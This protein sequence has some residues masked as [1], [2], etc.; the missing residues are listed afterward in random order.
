MKFIFS[1]NLFIIIIINKNYKM[2]IYNCAICFENFN[3]TNNT[4]CCT[5]KH[6]HFLCNECYQ[7]WEHSCKQFEKNFTCPICRVIIKPFFKD[8]DSDDEDAITIT[9]ITSNKN[10]NYY[11]DVDNMDVYDS[12]SIENDESTLPLKVGVLTKLASNYGEICYE[13]SYYTICKEL[14]D[15]S[16]NKY[17]VSIISNEVFDMITKDCI[18]ILQENNNIRY[19]KK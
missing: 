18:G 11:V 14:I 4:F 3:K 10:I 5:S 19:Y 16:G 6:K 7:N 2:E 15:N 13:N 12:D 8:Y 17:L 9:L 1:N